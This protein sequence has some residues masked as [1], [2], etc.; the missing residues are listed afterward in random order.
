MAMGVPKAVKYWLRGTAAA[1]QWEMQ[2]NSHAGGQQSMWWQV[3]IRLSGTLRQLQT[4]ILPLV[5]LTGCR[6]RQA[7]MAPLVAWPILWVL[8]TDWL[9]SALP[10][11]RRAS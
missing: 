6:L 3:C 9:P 10:E 1:V 7:A 2:V 4:S 5:S 11:A 8:F